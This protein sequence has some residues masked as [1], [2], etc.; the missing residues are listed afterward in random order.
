[1]Q[2]KVVLNCKIA[3]LYNY[4]SFNNFNSSKKKLATHVSKDITQLFRCKKKKLRG[5]IKERRRKKDLKKKGNLLRP[6]GPSES[7]FYSSQKLSI[8]DDINIQKR[9][10]VHP[11]SQSLMI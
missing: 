3:L 7:M 4:V 8:I 9:N 11:F 10:K 2:K 1:M 6:E 5:L